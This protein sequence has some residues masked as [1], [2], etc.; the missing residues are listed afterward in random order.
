VYQARSESFDQAKNSVEG[1]VL[2]TVIESIQNFA[3]R[4]AIVRIFGDHVTDAS[5]SSEF[6]P[7]NSISTSQNNINAATT[8]GLRDLWLSKTSDKTKMFSEAKS[9]FGFVRRAEFSSEAIFAVK[10][11]M[12]NG[13]LD[14]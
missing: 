5:P 9:D 7:E 11:F 12:S 1:K 4:S 10:K 14:A 6:L 3:E 2:M 8:S 13:C